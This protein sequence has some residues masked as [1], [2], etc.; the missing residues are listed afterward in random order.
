MAIT[1]QIA[2][3]HTIADGLELAAQTCL[4]KTRDPNIAKAAKD[5]YWQLFKTYQHEAE[6]VR[7]E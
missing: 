5:D 1:T 7:A 2:R 3:K 6:R 4:Q